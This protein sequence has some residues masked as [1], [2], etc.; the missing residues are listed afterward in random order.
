MPKIQAFITGEN[1]ANIEQIPVKRDWMDETA[2]RHA[3]NCFP[4][5]LSNTL[6]W[7]IS[8]PEDIEFIWDG[9][10][11]SSPHHVK[12]ISGEKYCNSNRSNGTIS[13]VTGFTFKTQ[14]DTT[15]LIMPA[16]NFFIPGG[17]AFTT[18]LTTSFFSGEIPV[19]WKITEANR[20]I[21][22]PAN[23]PVATIIP[24]SLSRLN[25]FE[26]DIYD[27]SNYVGTKFDGRAYGMTIDKLNAEGKWS[28]FYRNATDHRGNKIGSHE[29]KTLR[30]KT[31][32][33]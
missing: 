27:G 23:T 6:G 12:I 18:V 10:S 26:L 7:G 3:Y 33:K 25:E 2:N 17:Q 4:V 11:D 16:P 19:V 8:F 14:E 20:V 15:T 24:I 1:P 22:I 21:K 31:N 9:V 29:L 32:V 13:F 30:L 5:S 28:G